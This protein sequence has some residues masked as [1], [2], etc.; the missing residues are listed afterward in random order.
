[1]GAR[2]G[3]IPSAIGGRN[4]QLSHVGEVFRMDQENLPRWRGWLRH[5]Y[6]DQLAVWM[7][8]SVVGMAIPCMLSL[9]FIRHAP[10]S[11]DRVAAMTGRRHGRA[12]SCNSV[13]FLWSVTLLCGF[14]VLAPGQI[15]AGDNIS[16]RW[17][18]IIW[19]SNSRIR[20]LPG[21]KVRWVYYSILATYC[22]W[23]LVDAVAVRSA[24]DRQDLRRADERGV[25]WSAIH[26]VYVNRML[27]PRACSLLDHATGP[28][29]LRRVLPGH[30]H[31]RDHEPVRLHVTRIDSHVHVWR[32]AAGKT[33][34]VQTL[35]P[36][37]PTCRSTACAGNMASQPGRAGCVGAAGVS[38]RGQ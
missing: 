19:T 27:M 2:V 14:L 11:G 17:T 13:H 9:E 20:K 5:V 24:A 15:L 4:I 3:T 32:A 21:H 12:L 28:H 30:Q 10:V 29:P 1:M 23:G 37:Q 16:R 25:G 8:A 6:R 35:V 31:D 7:L 22:V 38:R 36:P 33:P 18:D 34:A 26:A